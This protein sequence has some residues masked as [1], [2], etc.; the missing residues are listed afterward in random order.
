MVERK[1]QQILAAAQAV[2]NMLY[3]D[4]GNLL[5]DAAESLRAAAES[6]AGATKILGVGLKAD[7]VGVKKKLDY[8]EEGFEGDEQ[9]LSERREEQ[10]A[11]LTQAGSEISGIE[12]LLSRDHVQSFRSTEKY[13]DEFKKMMGW[14][15]SSLAAKNLKLLSDV[16]D[17]T[18]RVMSRF[19]RK[20]L[21]ESA[22]AE[23]LGKRTDEALASDSLKQLLKISDAD[24]LAVS[25]AQ[26]N[27]EVE[28]MMDYFEFETRQFHQFM[29]D[30]LA[31]D[32]RDPSRDGECSGSLREF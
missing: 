18:E 8:A 1:A 5:P 28:K 19:Q 16:V 17:G 31:R 6:Q 21:I 14:R 10:R 15:I 25:S 26:Q 29:D 13:L 30:A 11:N 32:S 12:H 20:I 2:A 9:F 4:T 22:D 27:G 24:A 23:A 7:F 3:D